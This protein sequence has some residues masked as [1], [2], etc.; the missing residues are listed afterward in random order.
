MRVVELPRLVRTVRHLRPS[1]VYGQVRKRVRGFAPLPALADDAPWVGQHLAT[2]PPPQH[3]S[4]LGPGRYRF[5]NREVDVRHAGRIDYDYLG[6]GKLWAY[7]LNYFAYLWQAGMRNDLRRALMLKYAARLPT[8]RE[9]QEPYPTS[10][11]AIH[12]TKALLTGAS[13]AAAIAEE[14]VL[15]RSLFA[16]ARQLSRNVETHLAGNHVLEN[17][18]ALCALGCVFDDSSLRALALPLLERE[19]AEQILPS[20]GHYERSPMYHAILTERALD[21]YN[22][23]IG[24]RGAD[25]ADQLAH[26]LEQVL[27]EMLRYLSA[28]AYPDGTWPLLNDAAPGIALPTAA[29][30]SYAQALGL[31]ATAPAAGGPDETYARIKAGDFDLHFDVGAI[32]PDYIPG[33]AHCDSL[34]VV[35]RRDGEPW[36]VDTGVST[37]ELGTRRHRERSTRAHNTVQLDEYEQSEIWGAFRVGRRARP[38]GLQVLPKGYRA[39]HTGYAHLGAQHT[40]TVEREGRSVSILDEVR[41]GSCRRATARW[42]FDHSVE[43]ELTAPSE[44]QTGDATLAFAGDVDGVKIVPYKQATGW[45][46]VADASCVEVTFRSTLRTEMHAG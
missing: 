7:N 21:V 25:F 35:C 44:V 46:Q 29:I 19:L 8:L 39:A 28:I 27:P 22:V 5:L 36:L 10:L 18:F 40:R 15:R 32:G 14:Q 31:R 1:Q 9:G 3:T 43:P 17:A 26:A 12:W 23:A 37:Y 20:G 2:T 38:T 45:N 13:T 11:R 42:H 41:L 24:H 4:H 34:A 33:H 30:L 6:E 16:Q